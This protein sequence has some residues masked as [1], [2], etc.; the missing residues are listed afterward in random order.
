MT[1]TTPRGAAV[2]FFHRVVTAKE[3]PAECINWP[4]SRSP[5]GYAKFG[6]NRGVLATCLVSRA[7]CAEVNGLPEDVSHEAAHLCGNGHL[8]CINPRH[9]SWKTSK[10][11]KADELSHGTRN[12]GE[13]NGRSKLSP[14]Q[15]K[16]IRSMSGRVLQK[17]IANQFSIDPSTVSIILSRKRWEHI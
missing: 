16:E 13:R 7:V 5:E 1:Q 12:Y 2:E 9:L 6:S 15:I 11:N 17:N 4:F 3:W 10:A 8:G 14:E